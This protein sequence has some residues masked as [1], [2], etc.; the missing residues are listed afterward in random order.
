M[1]NVQIAGANEVAAQAHERAAALENDAAQA[2]LEQERLKARLAWRV[3]APEG[4]AKMV[5]LLSARPSALN[6]EFVSTD[7]EAQYFAIQLAKI[8]ADA[9]WQ[10]GIMQVT[11]G[12]AV[13]FGLHIPDT[14][15]ESTKI[16]REI[17][18][19]LQI[20]FFTNS[21][22]DSSTGYGS[23]VPNGGTILIGSKQP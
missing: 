6:I 1:A 18:S 23:R 5:E 7:T 15:E 22:P 3:I 4:R 9:K 17:F 12:S 8:L 10:V 14:P 13:F 19:Q 20:P 16:I 2:R 11:Y 21:L